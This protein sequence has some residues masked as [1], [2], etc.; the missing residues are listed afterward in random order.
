MNNEMINLTAAARV[1]YQ[2]GEELISDEFVALAELIKNSYDADATM[3]KVN[4][5]TSAI[6]PHGQGIISIEDNG[7][8]MTYKLLTKVFLRISTNFKKVEKYSPFYKRR[9]LGEKG[10]GRLSIQRLGNHI[11]IITSPKIDRLKDIITE[12]EQKFYEEYN[13]YTLE[14]DWNKEFQDGEKNLSDIQAQCNYTFEPSATKGTKL[15]I[16]GIRNL[17]F[18]DLDK[19]TETRIKSEIFGLV[20]PF[21]QQNNQKFIIKMKIDNK[22]ISNQVIDEEILSIISDI[23]VK[24]NFNKCELNLEVE[25][26]KKY[27]DR[28]ANKL[29]KEMKTN[30]FDV[31]ILKDYQDKIDSIQ[32][33]LLDNEYL[34]Y[35]PYLKNIMLQKLNESIFANPGNFTGMLYVLEQSANAIKETLPILGNYGKPFSTTKEVKSVWEAARGV[36]LFRNEFRILPYGPEI[37]WLDF[38]KRA[39]REK[40]NAY[41]EH[42]V[43]GYIQLDSVSSENLKEQTNRLG[44]IKDEYGTNFLVIVRD[45]IAG[46][47]FE[48]DRLTRAKIK[49]EPFNGEESEVYSLDKNIIFKRKKNIASEK[50]KVYEEVE[51]QISIMAHKNV[52][53]QEVSLVINNLNKIKKMEEE[54]QKERKQII[55][56]YEKEIRTLK[57][58]VGLAGQGIIIETL[59][60][61]LNKISK[62]IKYNTHEGKKVMNSLDI[63][64]LTKNNI[65]NLQ[66]SN[67]HELIFLDQQ[68]EHLEPTYKKNRLSIHELN[69]KKFF[70]DVYISDGV[71]SRKAKENNTSVVLSGDDFY[72]N[73]NKGVL[74]TIFDNLF[75]NS[76]Y[77]LESFT[78][79]FRSIYINLYSSDR[80]I[81]FYDSG[82]GIHPDIVNLLFEPYQSMKPEGRGLGLYICRELL[83]GLKGKIE[84]DMIH[85]NKYGNYYK[86]IISF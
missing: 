84:L 32:I 75:I 76:L 61:E 55:F 49:S 40:A 1:I 29:I 56:E 23:S 31:E 82:Y 81:E 17:G 51:K 27:F 26:K 62:N 5:D 59:T 2:L 14:I 66:N 13:K 86:I 11:T 54:Q 33:N 44:L 64:D 39:T 46:I 72:I 60:H 78:E 41:K 50:T 35:Y 19:K 3:V 21:T 8:G 79:D 15:I 7:N 67:L 45:I 4:I 30:G 38:N 63:D 85:K 34:K 70:E 65:L 9:V 48:K 6:T 73:S 16:Q 18:W 43:S 37:D 20:S 74:I 69:F 12:E 22:S 71:M 28:I 80:I 25:Y 68:L 24:I 83:K 10:L 52:E 58:L 77:W 36:Y 42:T 53:P 47:L 57:T